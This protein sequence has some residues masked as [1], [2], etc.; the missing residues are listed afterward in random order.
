ML[1]T[2]NGM[3]AFGS[4]E[5]SILGTFMLDTETGRLWNY[6]VDKEMGLQLVPI[7]YKLL[8]G[9]FSLVPAETKIE[10]ER[11]EAARSAEKLKE[12]NGPVK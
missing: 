9:S 12:P 4:V 5:G 1:G 8:D 7:T 11:F 2:A 6:S 3:Y 10:L